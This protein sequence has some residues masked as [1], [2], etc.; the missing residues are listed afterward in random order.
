MKYLIVIF[1]LLIGGCAGI[2][3]YD[4]RA[5]ESYEDCMRTAE[6]ILREYYK[7]LKEQ[8]QYQQEEEPDNSLEN[9]RRTIDN[10]EFVQVPASAF[11]RE[12]IDHYKLPE[13]DLNLENGLY[14][15]KNKLQETPQI[16][17]IG[18]QLGI[19]L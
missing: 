9:Q 18:K 5:C 11:P 13:L 14:V 15:A 8:G 7:K 6:D 12:L 1:A 16:I 17:E 10:I 4:A 19:N 2:G 3:C